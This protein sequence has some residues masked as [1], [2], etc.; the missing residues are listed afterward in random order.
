MCDL[1]PVYKRLL[2]Y[3]GWYAGVPGSDPCLDWN[4]SSR[5]PRPL[6]P[7]QPLAKRQATMD[8]FVVGGVAVEREPP[9]EPFFAPAAS[10]PP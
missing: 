2:P 5:V 10:A 3:F 4:R 1:Y 8:E 7:L 6:Q 9:P